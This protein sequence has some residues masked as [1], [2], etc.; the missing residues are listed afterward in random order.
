MKMH[1]PPPLVWDTGRPWE[2]W[3]EVKLRNHMRK[4][5]QHRRGRKVGQPSLGDQ[6]LIGTKIPPN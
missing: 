1:P 3:E 4:E 6:H 5:R 2:K